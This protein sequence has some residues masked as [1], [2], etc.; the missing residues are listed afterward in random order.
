MLEK[1][2][3]GKIFIHQILVQVDNEIGVNE[4]YVEIWRIP[5]VQFILLGFTIDYSIF[6][7]Y[8][9]KKTEDAILISSLTTSFSFL[10]LSLCGFKL[11]AS[12]AVILFFGIITSYFA[13]YFIFRK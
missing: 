8:K 12:M 9:N 1:I 4:N 7:T 5:P 13:G 2:S 6:R 3:E 10:L 11:L